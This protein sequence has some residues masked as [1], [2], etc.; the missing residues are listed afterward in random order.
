MCNLCNRVTRAVF[1]RSDAIYMVTQLVT[2]SP[3]MCNLLCN[4]Y[5]KSCNHLTFAVDVEKI[6]TSEKPT[7]TR[8][9][10]SFE[11]KGVKK[12]S[13]TWRTNW[14]S[15][16]NLVR[17]IMLLVKKIDKLF[18]INFLMNVVLLNFENFKWLKQLL[19]FFV[20]A[21]FYTF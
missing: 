4:Q 18:L 8:I 3:P 19:N 11:G 16:F 9:S 13:A 2:H 6:Y 10:N 17:T 7:A 15:I 1:W 20:L 14:N 21:P 5:E 12:M